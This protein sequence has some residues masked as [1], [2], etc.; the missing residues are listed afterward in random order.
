MDLMKADTTMNG[1]V[2]LRVLSPA[3][4]TIADTPLPGASGLHAASLLGL[5]PLVIASGRRD[6]ANWPS[7]QRCWGGSGDE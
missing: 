2:G 6:Q 4:G 7:A 3:S 1:G 5:V